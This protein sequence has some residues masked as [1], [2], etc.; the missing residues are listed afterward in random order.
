MF[1]FFR[2]IPKIISVLGSSFLD[3]HAQNPAAAFFGSLQADTGT[4]EHNADAGGVGHRTGELPCVFCPGGT[5]YAPMAP[6]GQAALVGR[7][8]A[9]SAPK[10]R[11]Y[12]FT[13]TY[14]CGDFINVRGSNEAVAP[15]LWDP[16][17]P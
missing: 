7:L 17:G 8:G 5:F 13:V 9:E 12:V 2:P 15:G 1:F 10:R 3:T 6:F 11:F 4:Q 14:S 16:E